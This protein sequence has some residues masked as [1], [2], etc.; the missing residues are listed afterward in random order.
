[1]MRRGRGICALLLLVCGALGLISSSQTWFLATVRT[2]AEPIEVTGAQ[3]LA[4][5]TPLSLTVLALAGVLALVALPL[6]Y[7]FSALA[8]G[9]AVW[10]FVV[11]LPLAFETPVGAVTGAITEAT[12][13]AGEE[14]VSALV[15][16]LEAT[17]WPATTLALWALLLVVAVLIAAT[18]HGWR[19]AGKR[20]RTDTEAHTGPVDAIDSWDDLS[21]GTDPTRTDR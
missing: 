5:L 11:N 17:F 12:G 10:M 16:R 7:L 8:A 18:A 14:A 3:A 19:A 1:M 6:R 4:L 15:T 21:R 13:L 2:V 20:F 9:I